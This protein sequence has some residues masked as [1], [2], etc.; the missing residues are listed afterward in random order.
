MEIPGLFPLKASSF[1]LSANI[2]TMRENWDPQKCE[3]SYGYAIT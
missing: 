1:D 2:L 3:L